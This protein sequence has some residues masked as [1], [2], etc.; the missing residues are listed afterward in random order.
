MN[1]DLH[2]LFE[3]IRLI[4]KER[5]K[6]KHLR[7]IFNTAQNLPH[8][9]IIDDSKLRQILINLIGNAIKFTEQ[10]SVAVRAH[11]YKVDDNKSRLVVEIQDS[12]PGIPENEIGNLFKHFVQTSS[13]IKKGS[14][15][16]LGLALSQELALLMGGNISASSQVGKGSVFTL[17]LEIKEAD[18]EIMDSNDSKR[19]MCIENGQKPYRIL[20]VDDDKES[21]QVVVFLLQLVGFET[22]EAVNGKEAITKFEEWSP[23]LILMDLRMPVMDG[24]EATRQ[25]L[26]SEKG[27]KTPII[28]VTANAFDKDM[29]ETKLIG[30]KDYIL[31]P[32]RESELFGKIGKILGIKYIY[33]ND[34][35]PKQMKYLYDTEALSKVVNELPN[36]LL[37][38]M[39]DA[40]EVADINQ[41]MKLINKIEPENS[42]LSQYLISLANNYDYD[43]LQKILT[44]NDLNS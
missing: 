37:R 5:A 4:F 14:G 30:M 22:N 31:K 44:Q 17:V 28:A 40:I 6:M 32:F 42:E 3:D 8:Y 20:I 23:D 9:V 35:S 34:V 19:V 26:Q 24:Y 25:I 13:G 1:V 10:G 7:Y 21:L 15:T 38:Q 33:E 39:Q 18:I 27:N 16:G 29:E 11:V 36:S 12:G 41:L 2:A 43:Y